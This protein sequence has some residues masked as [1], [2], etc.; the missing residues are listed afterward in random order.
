[1]KRWILAASLLLPLAFAA[2]ATAAEPGVKPATLAVD[3]ATAP[4]GRSELPWWRER[5]DRSLERVRQ[6]H[7]DLIWLGDSITQNWELA[8]PEPFADYR[9][10]WNRFYGDRQAVNM[11]FRGDTT[12]SVIWRLDHGEVAGLNPRALV[13]LIGAN[14]FGHV[15]WDASQTL[16]GINAIVHILRTKLP[17]TQILLLAV[18]PSERSPWITENTA[19]VNAMLAASYRDR[20]FVTF[21]NVGNLFYRDGRVNRGLYLDPH[22]AV[23][24]SHAA[25]LTTATVNS[26]ALHPDA[27]GMALIAETIEP[28][29]HK[30][31]AD[32]DHRRVPAG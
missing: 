15:H 22:Q 24:A 10:V 8:G 14:N 1:M 21:M 11:G 9:P 16:A 28:V 13:L 31:M 6:G 4:I 2:P 18:L 5:F 30:L 3:L 32:R 29:L 27:Q 23:M 19:A 17:D 25:G 26:I 12:A 7:V 20:P